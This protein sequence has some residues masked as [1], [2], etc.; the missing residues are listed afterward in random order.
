MQLSQKRNIF[1]QSFWHFLNLHSILNI[2]E[3]NVRVIAHAF[4]KLR[5]PK[6]VVR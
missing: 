3:K 4:L 2:L 5:S 1:S 6:N